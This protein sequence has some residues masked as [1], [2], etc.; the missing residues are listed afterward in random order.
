MADNQFS[1][2][3]QLAGSKNNQQGTGYTNLNNIINANKGNQLGQ[4]VA[5]N[6]K[7]QIGNIQNQLGQQQSDFNTQAQQNA[8]GSDQDAQKRQSILN[9][10]S[11]TSN[12][13]STPSSSD[14]SNTAS[15]NANTGGSSTSSSSTPVIGRSGDTS[16]SGTSNT[17][18]STPATSASSSGPSSSDV[19]AFQRYMSGQYTGPQGLADTSGLQ[20]SASQLKQEASNLS[21]S[22][23][24]ALLNR[25][26]GGNNYT[27]GQ[28][29]LDSLLMNRSALTP[30]A[31]QAST[32]GNVINQADLAASGQAQSYQNQAQNFANETKNLVNQNMSGI[33]TTI[34]GQY[35]AAQN[36]EKARQAAIGQI[37][38]FAS[39]STPL[40]ALTDAQIAANKTN[41]NAFVVTKDANGNPVVKDQYGNVQ[42]TT[43]QTGDQYAQMDQLQNLL[44]TTGVDN[45]TL[46]ALFGQ[47]N[48]SQANTNLQDTLNSAKQTATTDQ[49]KA[50]LITGLQNDLNQAWRGGPL[51]VAS[52]KQ[53]LADAMGVPI[54]QVGTTTG[55]GAINDTSLYNQ[56]YG[57]A[58]SAA[59]NAFINATGLAGQAAQGGNNTSFYNNLAQTLANSSTPRN[60]TAEGVALAQNPSLVNNYNALNA[61]MG[62]QASSSKYTAPTTDVNGNIVGAYQAGNLQIDPSVLAKRL[63]YS[64]TA[65]GTTT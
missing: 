8:I 16:S 59:Q 30:V 28:Q 19:S 31:R 5:G 12:T 15:G 50:N 60:L 3:S 27:Q 17:A 1:M 2:L 56:E 47:G 65:P 39:N 35:T 64:Y 22:G 24:Q 23:T 48:L 40:T 34:Q 4:A 51:A 44:K 38:S 7:G 25:T 57:T 61:L 49:A 43:V 53:A 52:A 6:I 32:L 36:A 41:P 62:S 26:V 45:S 18:N 55:S 54:S 42:T 63:G 46:S 11:G 9:Q 33:D 21:P 58:K 14:S 13:S 37:Q 20:S 10:Y 29:T